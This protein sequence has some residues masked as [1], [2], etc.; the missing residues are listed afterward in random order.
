[1]NKTPDTKNFLLKISSLITCLV[2]LCTV[3]PFTTHAQNTISS[4]IVILY[5]N[6]VHCAVEGYSKLLA[7]KNELKEENEYVGVVSMGDFVQGDTLGAISKGEYIINMMNMVEYDAI[8]LGNHEFDYKLQRLFELS[9]SL[10]T[11]PVCSNFY[12]SGESTPVFEPYIIKSYG[13]IDIAYIG[14]TTPDTLTSS[15]PVQF[16]DENGKY[17]YNFSGDNLYATVQKAIDSAEAAGAEYIVGLAHLGTE[18][19]YEQWSTPTLIKNTSG[20]DV[21]LDGHS[22]SIV[23][24]MT[25]KDKTGNDVTV[26]STGTKFAN[27][28]KLTISEDKIT[29]ELIPTDT[30]TQTDAGIDEYIIK[31]KEEYSKLGDRI[32]GKS[33]YDLLYADANGNRLVRNTETNLGDFCADAFRVVT[34]ADIGVINGGGIRAGLKKGD[35]TFNDIF[36]IFPFNNTV[37][38]AEVT[39]QQILDFLELSVCAYPDENGSFQHVSGLTYTLNAYIPSP[40]KLDSNMAFESIDGERRVTDVKILNSKT[41]EYEAIKTTKNYT[42]ASHNYLLLDHGSGATMFDN[43]K[44]ISNNGMLDAELLE[45]YINE[46]L[47]GVV[48]KEYEASQNRVT[49]VTEEQIETLPEGTTPNADTSEKSPHTGDN[50]AYVCMF[51]ATSILVSIFSIYAYYRKAKE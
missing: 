49:V 42:I 40:V 36:S 26:S 50:R 14:V 8:G 18:D 12:K 17:I 16:M 1:M 31:I 33:E 38:V 22:H 51:V 2:L 30:Y 13:D 39:G 24:G 46:H 48:G 21:V 11:K 4:D 44:I 41:G 25:V 15:S 32:I 9:D 35:I 43:A 6:D 20:F 34:G 47:N 7:L 29:T 5:E 23:E 10:N 37:C 45:V 3:V 28:G 27:I 19:V